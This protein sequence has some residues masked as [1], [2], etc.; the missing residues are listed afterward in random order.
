MTEQPEVTISL[1]L[2]IKV[3][4]E[5]WTAHSDKPL[6]PVAALAYVMAMFDEDEQA[7]GVTRVTAME[8]TDPTTG[9]AIEEEL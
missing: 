9:D 6:T 4:P 8:A 5:F 1:N 3:Q 7:K 2:T